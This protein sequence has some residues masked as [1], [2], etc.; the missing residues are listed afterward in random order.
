MCSA[1]GVLSTGDGK[2][3]LQDRIEGYVHDPAFLDASDLCD[4]DAR[5][6]NGRVQA[7]TSNNNPTSQ[8]I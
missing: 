8:G 3:L 4:D 6:A 1:F 5:V 2:A 7:V